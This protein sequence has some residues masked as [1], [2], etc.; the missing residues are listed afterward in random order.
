MFL[1]SL[2]FLV[3]IASKTDLRAYLKSKVVSVGP[4]AK[5]Q[6]VNLE[7]I[8]LATEN[9]NKGEIEKVKDEMQKVTALENYYKTCENIFKYSSINLGKNVVK[10]EWRQAF[11]RKF[12]SNLLSQ[13]LLKKTKDVIVRSHLAGTLISRRMVI[14]IAT[15][16]V[17]ANDTSKASKQCYVKEQ[18]I[19]KKSGGGLELT[20]NWAGSV[21]KCINW[22]KRKGAT[23][24][25]EHSKKFQK[26]E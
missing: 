9:V 17:K 26:E 14:A 22:T 8:I 13:T 24:K 20:E 3:K 10:I 6:I 2:C 11:I 18:V 12:G 21:L 23:Q 1:S 16:V 7:M 5:R 15:G 19:L 25:V 4:V